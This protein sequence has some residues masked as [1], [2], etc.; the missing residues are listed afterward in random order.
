MTEKDCEKSLLAALRLQGFYAAH[1]DCGVDGFP[2][3]FAARNDHALLLEVKLAPSGERAWDMFEPSQPV[4]A[5]SLA[6]AGFTQ[7]YLCRF[8]QKAGQWF[9]HEMSTALGSMLNG[10]DIQCG[11][12]HVLESGDVSRVANFFRMRTG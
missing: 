6:K 4:F 11:D 5:H 9:V 10:P 8:S 3:I 7:V 1:I 2:D 12:I